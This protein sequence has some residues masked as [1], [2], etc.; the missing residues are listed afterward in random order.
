MADDDIFVVDSPLGYR[1]SLDKQQWD[2]HIVSGHPELTGRE[3][4][5]QSSIENPYK[6]F[7][8]KTRTERHIYY[9]QPVDRH[10]RQRYT[11]VVAAPHIIDPQAGY[12]VIT[13]FDTTRISEGKGNGVI[14]YDGSG[15]TGEL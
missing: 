5:V 9:S 2:M 11:K 3:S 15:S 7:Q 10:G 4:D 13:A 6:I 12:N 8:S 1:V 14:L